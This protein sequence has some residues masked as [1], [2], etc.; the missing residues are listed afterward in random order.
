MCLLHNK[1][2]LHCLH[3]S[4]IIIRSVH[5]DE[6]EVEGSRQIKD[7]KVLWNWHL[8]SKQLT[9]CKVKKRK[10]KERRKEGKGT[11]LHLFCMWFPFISG[12]WSVTHHVTLLP[13]GKLYQLLMISHFSLGLF[14]TIIDVL[15]SCLIQCIYIK[16]EP[17]LT[18]LEPH[19]RKTKAAVAVVE[20]FPSKKMENKLVWSVFNLTVKKCSEDT[21]TS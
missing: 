8:A 20:R 3:L 7:T 2:V 4:W 15:P 21:Q 12:K 6:A 14:I 5:S 17:F 11:H 13:V 9:G 18:L 1:S 19:S 10:K 16:W